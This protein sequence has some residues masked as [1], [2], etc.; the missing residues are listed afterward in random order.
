MNTVFQQPLIVN[1]NLVRL[2]NEHDDSTKNKTLAKALT[3]QSKQ[4]NKQ[5]N[6]PTIT[7]CPN[8]SDPYS[9]QALRRAAAASSNAGFGGTLRKHTMRLYWR[10]Q[11]N[12]PLFKTAAAM[13]WSNASDRNT[14]YVTFNMCRASPLEQLAE[15]E[16]SMTSLQCCGTCAARVLSGHSSTQNEIP[17]SGHLRTRGKFRKHAFYLFYTLIKMGFWP[18]RARAASYLYIL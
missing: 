17:V 6:K 5:T 2:N 15:R 1:I 12:I 4:T 18:I 3:T 9:S 16:N 14:V 13:V 8:L 10:L 11:L 7:N